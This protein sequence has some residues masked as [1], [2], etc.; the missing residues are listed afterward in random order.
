MRPHPTSLPAPPRGSP[1]RATRCRGSPARG[2][3]PP[4]V[5]VCVPAAA[6][7]EAAGWPGPRAA[8][9]AGV[10]AS[11]CARRAL[12]A[13][14]PGFPR[15][16]W[17]GAAPCPPP[18]GVA[19]RGASSPRSCRRP[20]VGVGNA[21]LPA[22]R[23]V[24]LPWQ[25]PTSSR[26]AGPG[27]RP[28][29][30]L[31]PAAAWAPA[32]VPW[33]LSQHSLLCGLGA[34]ACRAGSCLLCPS[35]A[36]A[37]CA[38]AAAA[39]LLPWG[40][41]GP[42]AQPAENWP[43]VQLL[44]SSRS[45]ASPRAC[46]AAGTFPS[47]S[48]EPPASES[49]EMGAQGPG[50]RGE[51]QVASQSTNHRSVPSFLIVPV[52]WRHLLKIQTLQR[53]EACTGV[54]LCC[55]GNRAQVSLPPFCVGSGC[56]LTSPEWALASRGRG[57]SR[58]QASPPFSVGWAWGAGSPA[59]GDGGCGVSGRPRGNLRCSQGLCKGRRSELAPGGGGWAWAPRHVRSPQVSGASSAV[60]SGGLTM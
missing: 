9:R 7:P 4:Q 18:R 41:R 1:E 59:Q 8:R 51:S 58:P 20:A 53:S 42:R 47:C 36:R 22:L 24:A 23:A 35:P 6:V 25:E 34:P 48:P 52:S 27:G 30:Q 14:D 21:R 33:A 43:P 5:R 31:C 10:R 44:Q 40:R 57:P 2:P 28:R 56:P 15:A 49:A 29:P 54:R 17:A 45:A 13:P 16:G 32:P 3:G 38:A 19:F 11:A 60:D 26:Q 39:P 55:S 50:A 37:Q 12:P 46:G